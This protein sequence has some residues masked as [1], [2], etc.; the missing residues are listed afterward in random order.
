MSFSTTAAALLYR[1]Q[2]GFSKHA[3][4]LVYASH[5]LW[6]LPKTV[7][8]PQSQL[9][10]LV[11]DASFNPP[12]LA[13]LALANSRPPPHEI[14][15]TTPNNRDYDA[16]LLVLSVRNADKTL[17]PGD[18]TY[19]Q[20]LEMLEIFAQ[21]IKPQEGLEPNIAI[22]MVDEPTF[23][24]KSKILQTFLKNRLAASSWQRSTQLDFILG[25]DT[26]ERLVQPRYY[27][28][29]QQM[30]TSLRHFFSPEGDN[31]SVVCARRASSSY[32]PADDVDHAIANE[33]ISMGRINFIDIGE[34]LAKYSSSE[35]RNN[36]RQRGLETAEWKKFVP[37]GIAS[38]I[39]REGLYRSSL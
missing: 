8:P 33:F 34:D 28:S 38:Y 23:V 35:V 19:L 20:R 26:L 9:R 27:G 32:I 11:L 14:D 7:S 25:F 13:H 24:G 6:P 5:S 36:I 12:T 2:N 4:E 15:S 39:V 18:A 31:S 16:K 29:E 21:A 37:L 3:V 30:M 22:A 17:K 1:I 10:I